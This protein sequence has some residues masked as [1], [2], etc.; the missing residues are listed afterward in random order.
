MEETTNDIVSKSEQIRKNKEQIEKLYFDFDWSIHK[1]VKE[2]VSQK[3][4]YR[5]CQRVIKKRL[6][7]EAISRV[8]LSR[9]IEV[10]RW[11]CGIEKRKFLVCFGGG[12]ELR[13][14]HYRN[15]CEAVKAHL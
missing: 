15:K 4:T 8:V 12:N 1:I 5:I 3:V 2:L 7:L 10:E 6:D 9:R 14:C 13:G 11:H